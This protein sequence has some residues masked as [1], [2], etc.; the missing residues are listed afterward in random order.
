[1]A[2]TWRFQL[3]VTSATGL[4]GKADQLVRIGNRAPQLTAQPLSL[5]HRYEGGAWVARG[6]LPLPATDPDGDPV[7]LTVTLQETGTDGCTTLLGPAAT[8]TVSFDTRC[9]VAE[10]LIGLAARSLRVVASDGNGATTEAVFPLEITNR[11]PEVRLASNPAGNQ[12]AVDHG[13]APCPG[14]AGSCFVAAGKATFE[15]FDPDGDPVS[16]PAV[17]AAKATALASS[18]GEATTSAGTT[19]FRF[20]TPVGLPSQFRAPDGRTGFTLV[21]GAADSFGATGRLEVAIVALNRPPVRRLAVSS[22]AVPHVY[23]F[24]RASYTATALV[25]TFED[26]DGDPLVPS[27]ATGDDHCAGVTVVAGAATVGCAYPYTVSPGLPPLAAFMGDHP[28]TVAVTDGWELASSASRINIQNGAPSATPYEGPTEACVCVCA[29]AQADGTC[30]GSAHMAID[31]ANVALPVI[32]FD[33]DGD[34]VR[35]TYDV[36]TIGG[37]TERTV[38]PWEAGTAYT[39][40]SPPLKVNISVDDGVSRVTTTSTLTSVF[41]PVAGDLCSL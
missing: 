19:T 24:A 3:R 1:V 39:N 25:A 20:T 15:V 23:D 38:L 27:G 14:G 37:A 18:A 5:D 29:K 17:T 2:G 28:V 35:V 30:M 13:V 32:A 12:V 33:A 16:S 34:P 7:A 10:R 6:T 21:A 31:W 8:G 9:T 22:L 40:P 26:P 4:L 11:P 41:C 36:P